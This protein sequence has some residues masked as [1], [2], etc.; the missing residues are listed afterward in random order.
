MQHLEYMK[1]VQ[2][3]L[4]E[5]VL[6]IDHYAMLAKLPMNPSIASEILE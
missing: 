3:C 4:C 5:E 2:H 6:M 1:D